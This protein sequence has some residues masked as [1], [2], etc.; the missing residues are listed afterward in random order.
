MEKVTRGVEN[1]LTHVHSFGDCHNDV[2]LQNIM[3]T[4]D[5]A[6]VLIDFDSC[7]PET[8]PLSRRTMP[9]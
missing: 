4:D 8:E 7:M 5:D 6:A 9:G 1:S 2:N 3:L